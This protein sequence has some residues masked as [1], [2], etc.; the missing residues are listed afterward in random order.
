VRTHSAVETDGDISVSVIVP[1]YNSAQAIGL[2]LDNLNQQLKTVSAE[3]V[4][5]DSSND[6]LTREI[7]GQFHAVRQILLDAR[8]SPGESRNRGARE[9]KGKLLLFIDADVILSFGGIAAAWEHYREG[10]TVFGGAISL[11]K[12]SSPQPAASLEH[13]V[14]NSECGRLRKPTK[15]KNL[16]SACLAI[17][18]K[19]FLEAGGFADIPRMQDLELTERLKKSGHTLHFFPDI[20]CYQV[21]TSSLISVLRKIFIN[22]HNIVAIRYRPQTWWHQ[23]RLF[24]LAPLFAAAKFTRIAVRFLRYGTLWEKLLTILFSRLFCLSAALYGLGMMSAA[25]RNRGV[26]T[27]R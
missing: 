26:S 5:V 2:C 6:T 20:H 15:R 21:Q 8:C 23:F 14:F 16:S 4:V 1:S 27:H 12:H 10:N 9:A 19:L 25:V 17:E 7:I 22:G 3:I 24:L 11:S 18:K 13:L